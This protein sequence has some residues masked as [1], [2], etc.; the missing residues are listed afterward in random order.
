MIFFSQRKQIPLKSNLLHGSSE[1][2]LSQREEL[3]SKACEYLQPSVV[4]SWLPQRL[5]QTMLVIDS[6]W[7]SVTESHRSEDRV[8]LQV[9]VA[10]EIS[11]GFLSS[12]G[13]CPTPDT[14]RIM[15]SSEVRR[16]CSHLF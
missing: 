11:E 12:T 15:A 6:R 4:R 13:V 16:V 8:T 7:H 2:S 3:L 10:S 9:L 14:A 5:C 1:G